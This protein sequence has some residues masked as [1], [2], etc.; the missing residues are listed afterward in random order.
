MHPM[1]GP[2]P[3]PS[4]NGPPANARLRRRAGT[5]HKYLIGRGGHIAA[6]FTADS[7]P[8]DARVIDAVVRE[9]DRIE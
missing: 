8:M 3:H 6:V 4:T 9:L 1:N 2:N 5:V 7:E